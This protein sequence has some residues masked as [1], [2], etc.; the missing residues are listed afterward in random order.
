MELERFVKSF[1]KPFLTGR[2]STG[3]IPA[4]TKTGITDVLEQGMSH[5]SAAAWA[6]F[7]IVQLLAKYTVTIPLS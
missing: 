2:I 1:T 5:S 4:L 7:K 6:T 3:Q